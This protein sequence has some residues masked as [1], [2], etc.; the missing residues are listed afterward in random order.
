MI[1]TRNNMARFEDKETLKKNLQ[2]YANVFNRNSVT[3]N[4][5][6][7]LSEHNLMHNKRSQIKEKSVS[8]A[9][10]NMITLIKNQNAIMG[11]AF[12]NHVPKVIDPNSNISS[13]QEHGGKEDNLGVGVKGVA[14]EKELT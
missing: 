6:I 10:T 14:R 13:F 11:V 4:A 1:K 3:V 9:V 12:F 8:L 2:A 7:A 5:K